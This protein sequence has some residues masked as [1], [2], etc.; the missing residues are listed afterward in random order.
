VLHFVINDTD[1]VQ[2]SGENQIHKLNYFSIIQLKQFVA[3]YDFKDLVVDKLGFQ[4]FKV[5]FYDP[6][7]ELVLVFYNF[8][9]LLAGLLISQT[10][11]LMLFFVLTAL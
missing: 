3:F 7:V 11:E 10:E 5:G 8:F 9:H 6:A 4:A 1:I 2:T